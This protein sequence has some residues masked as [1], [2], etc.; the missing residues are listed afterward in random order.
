[1]KT[2]V[3]EKRKCFK[4]F[5]AEY[6][7]LLNNKNNMTK[8]EFKQK[9]KELTKQYENKLKEIEKQ[10]PIEKDIENIV[11]ATQRHMQKKHG[12]KE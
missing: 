4:Q 6:D 2:R 9:D 10:Y 11:A 5:S 1:M 3:T 12:I 7:N 8:S